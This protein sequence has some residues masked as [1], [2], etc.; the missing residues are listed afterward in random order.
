M[1]ALKISKNV[2]LTDIVSTDGTS[3]LVTTHPITG[4]SQEVRV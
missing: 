4:S 2:G 3:P 1:M